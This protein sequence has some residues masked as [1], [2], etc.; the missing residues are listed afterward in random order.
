MWLRQGPRNW[1]GCP[2]CPLGSLV[3]KAKDIRYRGPRILSQNQIVEVG[4][5]TSIPFYLHA[6]GLISRCNPNPNATHLFNW[7]SPSRA[8]NFSGGSGSILSSFRAPILQTRHLAQGC[9]LNGLKRVIKRDPEHQLETLI[10]SARSKVR[11]KFLSEM[12]CL[13][14][15]RNQHIN[16]TVWK[17]LFNQVCSTECS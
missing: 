17:A 10:P 16:P 3:F 2:G 1:A 11:K 13:C 8:Q 9:P 7:K 4:T 14:V 6:M 15:K 12:S 5:P